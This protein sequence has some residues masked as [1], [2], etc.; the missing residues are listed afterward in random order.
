MRVSCAECCC[1]GS[2]ATG[3]DAFS[4]REHRS[5][6]ARLV[7]LPNSII[8]RNP[9]LSHVAMRSFKPL[10]VLTAAVALVLA[11]FLSAPNGLATQPK[12]HAAA[13]TPPVVDIMASDYAFE[14]PDV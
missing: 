12:A 3:S 5:G 9:Y 10:L 2:P 8:V 1:G 11:A 13:A 6:H 14:A 4:Q 7:G